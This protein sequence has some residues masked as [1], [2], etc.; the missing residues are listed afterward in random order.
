MA[1]IPVSPHYASHPVRPGD[2]PGAVD[3]PAAECL[4]RVV[5]NEWVNGEYK[6]MALDAP[7]KALTARAGQF[8]QL[9]CPSP[10]GAEVWMRRPM[11]IYAVHPDQGRLLVQ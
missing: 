10:D 4:C 7:D 5:S 2:P 8:F 3:L 1:D 6:L 9:L 11:S